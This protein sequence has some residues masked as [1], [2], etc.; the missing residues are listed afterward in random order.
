MTLKVQ[1][2]MFCVARQQANVSMDLSIP[3]E[4][5]MNGGACLA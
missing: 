3:R 5:V 4:T 2:T 1:T